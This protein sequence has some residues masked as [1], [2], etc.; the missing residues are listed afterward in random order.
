M[1]ARVSAS[2]RQAMGAGAGS[3]MTSLA[4]TPSRGARRVVGALAFVAPLAALVAIWQITVTVF[5]VH[6]GIFPGV[7]AVV[8]AGL[9]S[10]GDGSLFMHVGASFARVLVGT[11]LALVTAIPL[12]VAM[13]ISPA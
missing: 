7:P 1:A 3:R 2:S 9:E 12:G 5:N 4:G 13:G 8:R 10:I 6:P 11:A